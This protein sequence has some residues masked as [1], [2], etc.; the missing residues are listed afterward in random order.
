M[1]EQ[2]APAD[3]NIGWEDLKSN[4]G[5][6]YRVKASEYDIADRPF[7][8]EDEPAASG[9]PFNVQV[10]WPVG[11]EGAPSEEVQDKTAITYYKLE[12]APWYSLFKYKLT[13]ITQDTYNYNFYDQEPDSY[14]LNIWQT[15]GSH[16]VEFNSKNPTI[17]SI[18][19]S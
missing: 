11:S 19:G 3:A 10:N 18:T 4:Q 5:E 13:I 15:A 1:A 8:P 9:P 7:G 14:N 17:T 2:Q 12:K 16:T 6:N